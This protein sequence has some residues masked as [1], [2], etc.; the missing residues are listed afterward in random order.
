MPFKAPRK[1]EGLHSNVKAI[2][3]R[4]QNNPR[5]DT[6]I[7][8]GIFGFVLKK[9]VQTQL[10]FKTL[11]KLETSQYPGETTPVGGYG[12]GVAIML[13]D[14]NVIS[15]KVGRV[16]GSPVAQLAKI[17]EPQ[18]S[19]VSVLI[20]HVRYP[21]PELMEAARFKETAQPYVGQFEPELTI[22]SAHNG[23]VENYKALRARM[24]E[25]VFESDKVGFV[26]S[27]IIPHYFSELINETESAD[28]ALYRLFCTLQ[29]SNAIGMFHLDAENAFLHLIHKGKTRGL[30]VWTNEKNEVVFCSRPEPVMEVFERLLMRDKFKEKISIKWNEDV[31]VK[32]SFPITF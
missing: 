21:S 16:A 2:N 22:V 29:G 26:D 32:L 9:P 13:R 18:V 10:I 14:G 27:E 6:K 12:A 7:M 28:E 1:N 5:R 19:E 23:K 30:T 8:C 20:A 31:G 17:V 25:H 15:E 11:Q 3:E 4:L 24:K